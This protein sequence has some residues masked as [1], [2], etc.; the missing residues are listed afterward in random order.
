MPEQAED[1]EQPTPVVGDGETDPPDEEPV[2]DEENVMGDVSAGFR[3]LL[4]NMLAQSGNIAQNNFITV[5]KAFDYDYLEGKRIVDLTEA[6]GAR[7]VAAERSPGGP[8]KPGA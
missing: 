5:A 3:D 1:F 6:L 4:H 7:E 2:M 8:K